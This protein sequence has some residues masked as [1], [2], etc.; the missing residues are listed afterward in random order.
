M[1][2]D[3]ISLRMQIDKWFGL[4]SRKALHIRRI[5]P[6]NGDGG[7]CVSVVGPYAQTPLAIVF[8]LHGDQ[9]WRVYP[10]EAE[11][12]TMSKRLCAA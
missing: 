3:R 4:D 12:P 2:A 9:S 7:R 6:A 1:G 8:F 10:P 11:R 5:G